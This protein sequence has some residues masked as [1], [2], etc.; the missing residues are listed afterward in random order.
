LSYISSEV[1]LI[2]YDPAGMVI[3]VQN[4]RNHESRSVRGLCRSKT[5]RGVFY[6]LTNWS[7]V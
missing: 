1:L 6:N 5:G 3:I 2:A 4:E 7:L